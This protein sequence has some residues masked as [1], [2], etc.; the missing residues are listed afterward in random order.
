MKS[1]TITVSLVAYNEEARIKRYLDNV[2]SVVDEIV[3]VHDGPCT[4]NTLKIAKKY[5]KKIFVQP[6]IG[7]GEPHRPFAMQQASSE[8]ILSLD[9]DEYLSPELKK[10]I[11]KLVQDKSVDGYEFYWSFNDKGH[12]VTSGPLSKSYRLVLFR[13]AKATAPRKP[14]E[15]YSVKGNIKRLDLVLEHDTPY[16]NWSL[17]SIGTKHLPRARYDARFRV[18]NGYATKS[19]VFYFFKSILS[20]GLL[21]YILLIKK[22][23]LN[24]YL[25]FRFSLISAVYNYLVNFYIFKFKLTGKL[26]S[27]ESLDK[28]YKL[29]S[30]K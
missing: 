30:G 27:F 8:W 6:R 24:G 18:S 19:S 4:D 2:K 20:L 25:G 16:H 7:E 28:E 13:K 11:K 15:W 3:I 26:P 10:N 14:H 17:S 12:L 23:F 5:T 22:C 21:P 9:A 29:R 1:S